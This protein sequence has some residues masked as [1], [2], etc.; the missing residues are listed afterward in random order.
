MHTW[1]ESHQRCVRAVG[2]EGKPHCTY[3][4]SRQ[5]N[6]HRE[7]S[8]SLIIRMSQAVSSS[9]A[10]IK[11]HYGRLNPLGRPVI[12]PKLLIVARS[13]S[14]ND[15]EFCYTS[16]RSILLIRSSLECSVTFDAQGGVLTAPYRFREC[17]IGS[18]PVRSDDGCSGPLI[19]WVAYSD[20]I[21]RGDLYSTS[22]GGVG[23]GHGVRDRRGRRPVELE[24][25]DLYERLW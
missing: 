12:Q 6:T 4:R 15:R 8:Q 23:K 7:C 1:K 16:S 22:V 21:I 24:G 9:S 20:A 2:C 3:G 25:G 13:A 14:S 5:G 19:V 11:L 17:Y 10:I 18:I